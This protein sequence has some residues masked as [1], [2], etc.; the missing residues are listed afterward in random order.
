MVDAPPAATPLACSS[1]P[2][3]SP[4]V[5][6]EVTKLQL[7]LACRTANGEP[8]T[9]RISGLQFQADRLGGNLA[10]AGHTTGSAQWPAGVLLAEYLCNELGPSRL[11]GKCVAELGGGLG[12]CSIAAAA[13]CGPTGFV[14]MTD[15]DQNTVDKA[16][17]HAELNREPSLDAPIMCRTLWWGSDEQ[18]RA[19]LPAG[20]RGFDLVIGS[21]LL[22][23]KDG[24]E[25][26]ARALAESAVALLDREAPNAAFVYALERRLVPESLLIDRMAE[27]GFECETVAGYIED[28]FGS[29]T[30]HMTDFWHRRLLSFRPNPTW[31]RESESR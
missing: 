6:V 15:G 9:I 16:A 14:L 24:A 30:D 20:R 11:A 12:L 2:P 13:V 4:E 19:L 28:V 18:A 1:T 27:L 21:D 5:P 25:Q 31:Q 23:E 26:R 22:Y 8:R 7:P 10:A 3:E 29:L 17:R